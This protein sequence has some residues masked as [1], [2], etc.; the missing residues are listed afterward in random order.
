MVDIH[1]MI[2]KSI[3][4]FPVSPLLATPRYCSRIFSSVQ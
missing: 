1:Q 2:N 3:R 4:L